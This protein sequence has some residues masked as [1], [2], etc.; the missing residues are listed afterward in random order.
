MT[1]F[2]VAGSNGRVTENAKRISLMAGE[3]HITVKYP[4]EAL[5]IAKISVFK[6]K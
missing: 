4:Q 3:N 2:T 5:S 1:S 6:E